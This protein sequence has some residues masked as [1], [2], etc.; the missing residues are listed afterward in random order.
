MLQET[1]IKKFAKWLQQQGAELLPLKGEWELIRFKYNQQTGVLY[2]NA[3]GRISFW[4][5]FSEDAWNAYR[6]GKSWNVKKIQKVNRIN[7]SKLKASLAARDGRLCFYC[8]KLMQADD[9]S[10]EHLL[11]RAAGGTNHMSNLVLAHPKC[12]QEA[13][14]L[15]I[16]EKILLRE[17]MTQ[18]THNERRSRAAEDE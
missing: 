12:N 17:K 18:E 3:K 1:R 8:N 2:C 10:I 13:H 5:D 16:I 14:N 7:G 11:S 15:P 9:M 4:N 6:E